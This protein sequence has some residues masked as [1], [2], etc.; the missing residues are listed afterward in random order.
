MR[1]V[2]VPV[3]VTIHDTWCIKGFPGCTEETAYKSP[4]YQ[5]GCQSRAGWVFSLSMQ[6]REWREFVESRLKGLI[7]DK[8]NA[9]KAGDCECIQTTVFQ[10]IKLICNTIFN[11]LQ[12]IYGYTVIHVVLPLMAFKSCKD[13]KEL[14]KILS[15][16]EQ[17]KLKQD[18]IPFKNG[19]QRYINIDFIQ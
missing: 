15:L 1:L 2:K 11:S 10:W 9:C 17:Y 16:V 18:I 14:Y 8:R 5:G 13:H 19:T 12:I 6:S 7:G 4:Y 3:T